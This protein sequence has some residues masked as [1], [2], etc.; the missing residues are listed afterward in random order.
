MLCLCLEFSFL[1]R[2]QSWCPVILIVTFSGW[3]HFFTCFVLIGSYF[4]STLY[5]FGYID[6]SAVLVGIIWSGKRLNSC[7][8]IALLYF[9]EV[10]CYILGFEGNLAC[11]LI[12]IVW[13]CNFF[14]RLFI[15]I[16]NMMLTDG[17]VAKL[18]TTQLLFGRWNEVHGEVALLTPEFLKSQSHSDVQIWC[19]I[20]LSWRES[21]TWGEERRRSCHSDHD[22]SVRR[23]TSHGTIV[24]SSTMAGKNFWHML[25]ICLV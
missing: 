5:A 19:F 15:D 6:Y 9:K 21:S 23:W 7:A 14:C 22:N 18:T 11:S 25:P 10:R 8:S 4:V 3:S 24:R 12:F 2:Y 16:L 1:F 13:C 20:C 17:G